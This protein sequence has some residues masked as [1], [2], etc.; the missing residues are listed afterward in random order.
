MQADGWQQR[1][2]ATLGGLMMVA[3]LMSGCA[4]LGPLPSGVQPVAA[5]WANR[6]VVPVAP[7]PDLTIWWTAFDDPGLNAVVARTV[8]QNLSIA[9]AAYRLRAARALIV[10]AIGQRLPQISGGSSARVQRRLSGPSGFA[11]VP[12]DPAL[13][14]GAGLGEAPRSVGFYQAGFDASWEIDLFGGASA[15]VASARA[16]AA[17]A[18][19]E[20]QAARVSVVAEVVRTYIELRG[21][22]RR[23][24]LLADILTSQTRVLALTRERRA[25]GLAG[26]FDVD[27]A[28]ASTAETGAPIPLLDQVVQQAA[29]RIAALTG[30]SAVDG[31]LLSA[32]SQPSAERLALRLLPADLVRTRPEILR[33]EFAVAQASAELDVSV[34]DLYPRLTLTGDITLSDNLIGMS[35]PGRVT[36]ATVGPAISIPLLDWGARRATVTARDAALAKALLAYRQAVLEGIEETENALNAV[37]AERRRAVQLQAGSAAARRAAA[38]AD[39]LYRQGLSSLSDTLDAVVALRQA[40]LNAADVREKQALAVV[41][42]YKAIGGAAFG[43]AASVSNSGGRPAGKA[44]VPARGSDTRPPELG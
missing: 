12:S 36:N 29:Q 24:A 16:G 14:G 27:R 22:Q 33:A 41:A 17:I 37:D 23:Q 40:E 8:D 39:R 25:A 38:N 43:G 13:G 7:G 4:S 44:P 1:R 35:L 10:P 32:G 2:A 26:D 30:Q 42:L 19:A 6:G 15:R 5:D 11:G 3:S 21:A 28:L 9:Q 18:E 31:T 20:A 34:A